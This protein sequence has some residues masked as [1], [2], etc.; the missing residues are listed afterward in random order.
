MIKILWN[1]GFYQIHQIRKM[2]YELTIELFE[3]FVYLIPYLIIITISISTIVT[4][5]LLAFGLGIAE[6]NHKT[7]IA[8]LLLSAV[9]SVV[10]GICGI[11][12]SA[13][14]MIFPGPILLIA[15]LCVV[16]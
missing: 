6:G 10:G 8:L 2:L 3:L 5:L 4:A 12:M 11:I 7:S 13:W 14:W 15:L 9:L 16:D 1:N